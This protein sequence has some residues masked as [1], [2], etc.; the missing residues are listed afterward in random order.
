[1]AISHNQRVAANSWI[2][3]YF[4]GNE[5]T[6]TLW[7]THIVTWC[8]TGFCRIGYGSHRRE[9]RKKNRLKHWKIRV[10]AICTNLQNSQH[11]LNA[12]AK[13]FT[14]TDFATLR[15]AAQFNGG[16]AEIVASASPVLH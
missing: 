15:M 16:S 4:L 13:S 9:T 5:K 2:R 11:V 14:E 7:R 6:R 12:A 3:V 1:M 8:Y 10:E